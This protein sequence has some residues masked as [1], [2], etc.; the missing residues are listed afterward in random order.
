MTQ[1]DYERVMSLLQSAE[2]D[3]AEHVSTYGDSGGLLGICRSMTEALALMG[4]ELLPL[5]KK[6]DDT[7]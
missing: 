1:A 4:V 3:L 7:K 2:K 5:E 6:D